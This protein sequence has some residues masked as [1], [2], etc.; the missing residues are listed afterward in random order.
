[1]N[2]ENVSFKKHPL[3]PTDCW[4]QAGRCPIFSQKNLGAEKLE[5]DLELA[6]AGILGTEPAGGQV[7]GEICL[8][9]SLFLSFY[10]SNIK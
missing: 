7:R 1:M 6:I 10:L 4:P 8:Q 2:W 9:L 3:H 5:L